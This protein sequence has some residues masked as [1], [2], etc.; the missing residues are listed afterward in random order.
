MGGHDPLSGIW[1]SSVGS[2]LDLRVN[3]SKLEGLFHSMEGPGGKYD[4]TGSVDPG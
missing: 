3:G 4:L 2:K 1:Y